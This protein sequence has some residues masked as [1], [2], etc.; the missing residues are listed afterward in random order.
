M[1]IAP[2][3]AVA[4]FAPWLRKAGAICKPVTAETVGA[5]YALRGG[6]A[7]GKGSL[8]G[9]YGD[10]PGA[11]TKEDWE[12]YGQDADGD[13]AIDI[14]SVA[15]ATVSTGRQLCDLAGQAESWLQEG[16]VA[17]DVLEVTLAAY[18]GSPE[19]VLAAGGLP[20]PV[21]DGASSV[22]SEIADVLAA[23]EPITAA[24][25][26]F[27]YGGSGFGIS[28]IVDAAAKFIGL[29][30]VWGGGGAAGPSMGGFDCSGLT[31]YAVNSALGVVIPR[32]SEEQWLV[33]S[34]VSLAEAKP[35]DLVFGEFAE[36]GPGHV[37]IYVGEGQMLHAP[38]S[39]DV[40]RI[41][42]VFPDMRARTLG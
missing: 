42:A 10:G 18:L 9:E 37:G 29:P 33:G 19:A 27:F 7:Y 17:G 2:I 1:E 23:R 25:A 32:T 38:T 35:G 13:G 26:P 8:G 41:S 14:T 20:S 40:V 34:E 16:A 4:V 3:G 24:L 6:F 15:D 22:A 30:Y 12:L 5:L 11:F 21:G 31:T 28:E 36:A 39:G